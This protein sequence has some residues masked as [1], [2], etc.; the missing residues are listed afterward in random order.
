MVGGLAGTMLAQVFFV[1]RV[2]GQ[3]ICGLVGGGMAIVLSLLVSVAIR[4]GTPQLVTS[5]WDLGWL[6]A[7]MVWTFPG[8]LFAVFVMPLG[9]SDAG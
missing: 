7:S 4:G 3:V 1:R 6:A 5:W 2:G 8:I 9:R